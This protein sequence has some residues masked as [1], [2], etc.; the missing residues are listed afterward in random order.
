MQD[1]TLLKD[2]FKHSPHHNIGGFLSLLLFVCITYKI[3]LFKGFIPFS[4]N[5]VQYTLNHIFTQHWH[6]LIVGFLPIYVAI[7]FFGAAICGFVFGTM[8]Q[9]WMAFFICKKKNK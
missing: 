2:I 6:V 3:L 4:I 8:L 7:V 1:M 9:Y 5:S